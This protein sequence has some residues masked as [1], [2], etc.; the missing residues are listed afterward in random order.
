MFTISID[1]STATDDTPHSGFFIQDE[2]ND[3]TFLVDTG[4]FIYSIFPVAEHQKNDLPSSGVQVI[5]AN[6]NTISTYGQSELTLRFY[7]RTY[8][9]SF[10]LADV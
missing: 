3:Y 8:N 4:A 10:I 2:I 9:W 5:A 1:A 7:G 6:G